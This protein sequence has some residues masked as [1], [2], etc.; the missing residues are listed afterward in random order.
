MGAGLLAVFLE[1]HSLSNV[2]WMSWTFDLYP[3]CVWLGLVHDN[4]GVVF[5]V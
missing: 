4:K 3:C 2:A 5:D 1:V